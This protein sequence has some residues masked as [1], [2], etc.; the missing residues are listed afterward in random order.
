MSDRA[1][2]TGW[3]MAAGSR[4]LFLSAARCRGINCSAKK[5]GRMLITGCWGMSICQA[6]E[7]SE[8]DSQKWPLNSTLLLEMRGRFGFVVLFDRFDSDSFAAQK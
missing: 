7:K 8:E 3:I 1:N 6:V 5:G 2:D 4:S